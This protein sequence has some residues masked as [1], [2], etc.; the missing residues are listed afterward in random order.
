MGIAALNAYAAQTQ[1]EL[2]APSTASAT[3]ATSAAPAQT[4]GVATLNAYAAQ[5]RAELA[6]EQKAAAKK[7]GIPQNF[8]AGLEDVLR[9]PG[10][11]LDNALQGTMLAKS[12]AQSGYYR[13]AAQDQAKFNRDHANLGGGLA[14]N[15]AR[16]AGQVV[17]AATVLTLGAEGLDGLA[18]GAGAGL[19]AMGA[20]T[21]ANVVR[22]VGSMA[23][24]TA[25]QFAGG[26]AKAALLRG[27][28]LATAGALQGAG[29]NAL[30]GRDPYT[31]AVI[32]AVANPALSGIGHVVGAGIGA[33]ISSFRPAA[34]RAATALQNALNLDGVAPSGT[35]APIF[36]GGAN[37]RALAEKLANRQ[38]AASEIIE[39][40]L[41]KNSAG[42]HDALANAVKDGLGTDGNVVDLQDALI[43]KQKADAKPLYDQA[44]AIQPK[45]TPRLQE[46]LNHPVLRTGLQHGKEIE[47][48]DALSEGVPFDE[49][50]FPEDENAPLPQ[51]TM[52]VL[53]AGKRGLDRIIS[54]NTNDFGK[55][56]DYARAVNG[57]RAAYVSHLDTLNPAYA[58]A[59]AA[60]AGPERVMQAIR[61]GQN[62]LKEDA[63]QTASDVAQLSPSEK[64]GFKTGVASAV[65]NKI[66]RVGDGNN[67]GARVLGNRQARARI[68]AAFD[69]PEAY[70]QFE[71]LAEQKNAEAQRAYD[72]LK[73][74]PSARRLVAAG[75]D[76]TRTLAH[77][78]YETAVGSPMRATMMIGRGLADHIVGQGAPDVD[79]ATANLLV[80]PNAEEV[81]NAL[82]RVQPSALR[83]ATG[84]AAGAVGKP[85]RLYLAPTMAP[86]NALSGGRG[87]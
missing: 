65:L 52:K 25:G 68:A 40:A 15:A 43:A 59:R 64:E 42:A 58:D 31:G 18:A 76:W 75:H 11:A 77:A 60:F 38:G 85:L 87:Q 12:L 41:K 33:G 8:Q 29:F 55:M 35:V 4:G 49:S 36:D 44:F 71:A 73:G 46:F 62:T 30:T 27:A 21:A 74:S 26:G 7:G 84:T 39:N 14:N 67:V 53:D 72:I 28:S 5:T 57:V 82:A 22:G 24:G 10:E 83:R 1:K 9:K 19:D 3:L 20:G 6:A 86:M 54:D 80:N 63:S 61:L 45:I 79:A 48:L 70:Q 50:A 2:A 16:F 47:S 81:A 78:G 56:N 32:G 69:D 37:V 51:P 34:D 17:P 13:T 23:T 66:D